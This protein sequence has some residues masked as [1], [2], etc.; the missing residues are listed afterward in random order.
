MGTSMR[1]RQYFWLKILIVIAHAMAI[2]TSVAETGKKPDVISATSGEKL[3]GNYCVS[4]HGVKGVGEKPISPYIRVPGFYEAPA[5]DRS[6]H[7]WHHTDEALLKT[8]LHGSPRT[9]RMPAMKDVITHKQAVDLVSYIKSLW[10]SRELNC[11][12]PKHM[13]CM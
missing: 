13:S 7:A 5:L 9:S 10:G 11:Q 1:H 6:M 12:G 3:F 2:N 4:C 8:I